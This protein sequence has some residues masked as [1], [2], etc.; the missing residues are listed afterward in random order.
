MEKTILEAFEESWSAILRNEPWEE[1]LSDR[2]DLVEDLRPLLR[3]GSAARNDWA[4]PVPVGSQ[5]RSRA[6][7]LRETARLKPVSAT[8]VP[9]GRWFPRMARAA[10][11]VLLAFAVG[12]IGLVSASARALPG[13]RLYP[14]KRAVEGIQIGLAFNQQSRLSLASQ[15]EHR[16]VDEIK[17]LLSQARQSRVEFEGM[18][19]RISGNLWE[20]EGVPVLVPATAET[21]PAIGQNDIVEIQGVTNPGGFVLADVARRLGQTFQ[22]TVEAMGPA[23]WRVGSHSLA[24][25]STSKIDPG[26]SIGDL[27]SVYMRPDQ[28]VD[29]VVWIKL[30]GSP[31]PTPTGSPTS[32]P[33]SMPLPAETRAEPSATP[34]SQVTPTQPN[35]TAAETEF[36]GQVTSQNGQTWVVSGRTLHLTDRTEIDGT[37]HVG[38][39]VTVHGLQEENGIVLA[40]KIELA[41]E[42]KQATPTPEKQSSEETSFRGIVQSMA[43]GVWIIG[44]RT[45]AVVGDTEIEGHPGVGDMVTVEA[46]VKADGTLVAHSIQMSNNETSAT[47]TPQPDGED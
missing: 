4:R 8:H 20:V 40:L 13:D 27:V 16:R 1:G 3:I 28:G 19:Q 43:A 15:Y 25:T 23:L 46:T 37:I 7:L 22:G 29:V 35:T 10:A 42:E 44:G 36:T 30:I 21:S 14:V 6:R 41:E 17:S 5:E 11:A 32:H 31:R 45:I 2:P 47:K 24:I 39:K 9:R 38:D 26:I 18:V 12:G 33:S 34:K